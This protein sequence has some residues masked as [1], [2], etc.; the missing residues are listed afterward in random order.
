MKRNILA[1]MLPVIIAIA[2]CSCSTSQKITITGNPGTSIFA[3]DFSRLG[4]IPSSGKLKI[5]LA[6]DQYWA[7]LLSGTANGENLVP[8]GLNYK[9]SK[10]LGSEIVK[11]AGFGLGSI[12]VVALAVGTTIVCADS[13]SD[14]GLPFVA[15]GGIATAL[16]GS[17]AAFESARYEQAAYKYHYKYLSSQ[18]TNQDMVFTPVNIRYRGVNESREEEKQRV[19]RPGQKKKETN[20]KEKITQKVKRPRGDAAKLA[21]GTYFCNG[22][23]SQGNKNLEELT[24]VKIIIKRLEN[25]VASVGIIERD[26]NDFFS[27]ATKF[28]VKRTD[29]GLLLINEE[30]VECTIKIDA[31]GRIEYINPSVEIDGQIYRLSLK[32]SEEKW[33]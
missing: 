25:N 23:I 16:G 11:D 18:N 29:G 31:D 19:G 4:Q 12:G 33:R 30:I 7:F 5:K 15:G 17:M 14:G 10:R 27:G 13:E 8:F 28:S 20:V 22:Y 32:T 24:D 2:F 3:P 21:A 1:I 9:N 26:G 6:D